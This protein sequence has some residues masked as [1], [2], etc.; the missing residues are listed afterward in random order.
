[1]SFNTET[2]NLL[3]V[4]DPPKSD[5]KLFKGSA[6][7]KRGAYAAISYM[8]CAGIDFFSLLGLI[9]CFLNLELN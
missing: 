9:F 6:M 2:N 5:D 4:S 8:S 7:T 1:M 3:P